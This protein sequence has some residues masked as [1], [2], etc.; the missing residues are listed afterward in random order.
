M[1]DEGKAFSGVLLHVGWGWG[2]STLALMD[3][4]T[5][6]PYEKAQKEVLLLKAALLLLASA[7]KLPIV[8]VQQVVS[9]LTGMCLQAKPALVPTVMSPSHRGMSTELVVLN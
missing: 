3:T 4:L 9:E 5:Q 2:A 1:L 8:S 7:G 6:H